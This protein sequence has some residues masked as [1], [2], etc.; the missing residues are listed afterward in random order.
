MAALYMKQIRTFF[1]SH[2]VD[3]LV[4]ESRRFQW[5]LHDN[6][7][8]EGTVEKIFWLASNFVYNIHF[9]YLNR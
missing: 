4:R 6:E 3:F 8:T 7:V 1:C 2:N 9:E 5:V